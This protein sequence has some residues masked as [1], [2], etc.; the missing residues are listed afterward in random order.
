MFKSLLFIVFIIVFAIYFISIKIR[1]YPKNQDDP[2]IKLRRIESACGII[3]IATFAIL[4]SSSSLYA[5]KVPEIIVKGI[6]IFAV[7]TVIFSLCLILLIQKL[8]QKLP[9]DETDNTF[10][11]R[12][13]L[14]GQNMLKLFS[15]KIRSIIP[16][17]KKRVVP[18][19]Q[20]TE[21]HSVVT[22]SN[23]KIKNNDET[24]NIFI[25]IIFIVTLFLFAT[26]FY[27]NPLNSDSIAKISYGYDG[28]VKSDD[29]DIEQDLNDTLN[30]NVEKLKRN[31]LEAWNH[32]RARIA[33]KNLNEQIKMYTAFIEGEGQVNSDMK[34]EYA[35]F[36]LFMAGRE[37][38]KLKGK[39]KGL[40]R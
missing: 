9:I 34:M 31:R 10:R 24:S 23:T 37:L 36:L 40:R 21:E 39:Q 30:L 11:H 38:R 19:Q 27:N 32:M 25:A 2:N 17:G 5:F 26:T 22:D 20:S 33:R 13:H 7:C 14:W 3:N 8:I 15:E 1:Q 29:S 6:A 12:L 18:Q 4:L 16:A 35:G 28:K